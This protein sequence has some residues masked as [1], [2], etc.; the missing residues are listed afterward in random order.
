MEHKITLLDGGCGTEMWKHA[1]EAGLPRVAA[2]RYNIEHP[3]IVTKV[4]QSYIEAGSDIFATNTF[5]ANRLA[6]ER[7]APGHTVPEV[8]KAAV[9][10][11]KEATSGTDA[12]FALDVGPLTQLLKPFG[13]LSKE[14]CESIYREQIGAGVEEGADLV[15]LETFMDLEMMKIAANIAKSFGV[16]VFASMTFEKKRRTLMGN[17]VKQIVKELGKIG[18]DAVGMN[19]SLGPDMANEII[20]EYASLT[21]MP[22]F[23]KPNAG[24][25]ILQDDGTDFYP[26]GPEQF[27]EEIAPVL[28]KVS[29]LGGCCGSTPEHIKVLRAAIGGK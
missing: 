10:L 21:D 9:N 16:K 19:C 14:D 12:R 1:G 27:A 4:Y 25:P 23:Y 17:S 28:D 29:Y 15:F 22:L 2:W 8:V 5:A 6:V 13:P 24:M 11:A 3:E 26:C 18:V 20:E 7:E